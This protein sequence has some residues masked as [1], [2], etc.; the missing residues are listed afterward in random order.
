MVRAL[1]ADK[2]GGHAYRAVRVDPGERR[3]E[4]VRLWGD[5]LQVRGDPHAKLDWLYLANPAGPGE[6]FV[7]RDEGETAVGCAGITTRELWRGEHA[8]R[9]A[10]L[11]DFAIDR[12]HR[13]GMPALILQRATKH[14][15]E[16]A[17]ELGYGFPNASAVAIHRRIGFF[18]LGGMTRY[19]RVLRHG[20][21]LARRYGRP[22][23]AHAAGAVVD[24][25]KLAVRSLRAARPAL[26][27]SLRWQTDFDPRFDD[28]WRRHRALWGVVCRRDAAFLR[29]RF[30]A[31]PLEHVRIATLAARR[32]GELLAYA[33][34]GGERGEMAHLLDLF[35]PLDAL[36]D[37]LTLLLPSLTLRGHTAASTRFLGDPRMA[38]LLVEHR[39]SARDSDRK[40]IACL[41]PRCTDAALRDAATWYLTDLD[42]DT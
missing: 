4:L 24:L 10:L 3:D 38:R 29:W 17:Y 27:A 42:E 23:A 35:G 21:Y 28:L 40:V 7:L 36:H 13:T 14:Q 31:K 2:P 20:G 22:L 39:M 30:V 32:G 25:A 6:A 18:E 16:T 19:V 11:A 41:S 33:V 9:A 12:A 8:L 1:A 26:G 5:N 37:L 34:V 15:V